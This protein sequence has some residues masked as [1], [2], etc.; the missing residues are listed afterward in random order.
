MSVPAAV[1]EEVR[2]PLPR[3][4]PEDDSGP[5]DDH[6]GGSGRAVDEVPLLE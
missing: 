4:D 2:V 1:V 5:A 6:M 3:A